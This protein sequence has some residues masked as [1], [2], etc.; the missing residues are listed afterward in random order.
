MLRFGSLLMLTMSFVLLASACGTGAGSL[1]AQT[2]VQPTE[3]IREEGS[4]PF[5]LYVSN[6]SFASSKVNI[7]VWVDGE[8]VIDQEFDVK[9]QHNW[10]LF[11]LPLSAGPHRI[12]AE[13]A[14]EATVFEVDIKLEVETW[15]VLSFWKDDGSGFFTWSESDR[16]VGFA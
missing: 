8:K 11:D 15:A 9:G 13:A 3:D 6:Q 14:G 5:H 12:R 10:I 16:P 7:T 4:L 2:P 1:R